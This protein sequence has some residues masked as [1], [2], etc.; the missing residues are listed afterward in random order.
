MAQ[1]MYPVIHFE[2]PAADTARAAKFYEGVFGWKTMATGPQTN[3]F[4]LAFTVETDPETRLPKKRGAI[5]GGIFKKQEPPL[6]AK[7]TVL[8]DD[9]RAMIARIE[10]AGGKFLSDANGKVIEMPGVGMFATFADPDGNAVTIYQDT[11][12]N[13]TPDQKALL[14]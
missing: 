4:V 5:N 7:I 9:I 1:K 2:L 13:P 8:V 14:G 6:P 3:D 11:T 10:A 12:P